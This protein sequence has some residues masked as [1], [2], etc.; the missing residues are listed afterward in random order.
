MI[1][2]RKW[3]LVASEAEAIFHVA[4]A[5]RPSASQKASSPQG[6]T[7]NIASLPHRHEC[8]ARPPAVRADDA[9]SSSRLAPVIPADDSSGADGLR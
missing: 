1:A 4:A 3:L 5:W 7:A 8:A 9:G 2:A 6:E